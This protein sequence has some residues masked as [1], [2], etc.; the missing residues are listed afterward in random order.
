MRTH[1]NL[2][3]HKKPVGKTREKLAEMIKAAMPE[4][5]LYAEDL[6]PQNPYYSSRH[7]DCCSWTLMAKVGKNAVN[8]HS[9][10]AMGQLVKGKEIEIVKHDPWDFE[11]RGIEKKPKTDEQ[12]S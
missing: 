10:Q 8:F 2:W 12:K 11:V 7:M 9:W 3:S 1:E 6:L 5:T 4:V